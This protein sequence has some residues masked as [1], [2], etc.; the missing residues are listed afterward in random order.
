M[1]NNENNEKLDLIKEIKAMAPCGISIP[2]D[3]ELEGMSIDDL[4]KLLNKLKINSKMNNIGEV[5][6]NIKKDAK[7]YD[8]NPN[9]P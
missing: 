4:K 2:T 3:L 7:K 8:N 1:E 5:T 6:E 9:I